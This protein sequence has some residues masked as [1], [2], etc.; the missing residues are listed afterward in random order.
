M[1]G[2]VPSDGGTSFLLRKVA[3]DREDR[4]V[5]EESAEQFGDSGGDV[6]PER[7]G[8]EAGECRTVVADRGRVSIQNLREP[9]GPGLE[10]LE[11]PRFGTTRIAEKP[12]M[13]TS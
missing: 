3:G 11:V 4:D 13:A 6:V 5:H 8:V 12:R 10:I 9:C 1:T 2:N 7:V